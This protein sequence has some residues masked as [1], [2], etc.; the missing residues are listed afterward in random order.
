MSTSEIWGEISYSVDRG[1][2]Y[3]EQASLPS[4][5]WFGVNLAMDFAGVAI[6][7]ILHPI[8]Q[9]TDQTIRGTEMM[10]RKTRFL[11]AFATPALSYTLGKFF[12]F[13]GSS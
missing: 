10:E 4:G 7:R 8:M 5:G 6:A 2:V 13:P 1:T 3:D 9:V 12:E 11:A